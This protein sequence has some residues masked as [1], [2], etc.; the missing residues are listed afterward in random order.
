M[1][2]Q[3]HLFCLDWYSIIR[4]DKKKQIWNLLTLKESELNFL[5]LEF[6]TRYSN[7]KLIMHN[8]LSWAIYDIS[9]NIG[10]KILFSQGTHIQPHL[11][12]V[13]WLMQWILVVYYMIFYFIYHIDHIIND[14]RLCYTLLLLYIFNWNMPFENPK[15][16]NSIILLW[17]I[18]LLILLS[19]LLR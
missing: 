17:I 3:R 1:I 15:N 5:Y 19:I 4:K 8:C 11:V 9:K 7:W 12:T 14:S 13:D 2:H 6:Q 18:L 16:C 10:H